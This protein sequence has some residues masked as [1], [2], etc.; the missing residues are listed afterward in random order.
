MVTKADYGRDAFERVNALLDEL[1]IEPFE[2][3]KL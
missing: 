2:E 1:N 3:G